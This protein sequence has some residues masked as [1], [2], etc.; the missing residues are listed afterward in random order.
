MNLTKACFPLIEALKSST[1]AARA[2]SSSAAASGF[3]NF[4]IDFWR[5]ATSRPPACLPRFLP[6]WK[7]RIVGNPLTPCSCDGYKI[8]SYDE[9]FN[10]KFRQLSSY[11]FFCNRPFADRVVSS[12]IKASDSDL[13]LLRFSGF[14]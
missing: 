5:E 14:S 10:Y 11:K 9:F 2:F 13:G 1:A 3:K 8:G 4:V 12:A 7:K 6:S